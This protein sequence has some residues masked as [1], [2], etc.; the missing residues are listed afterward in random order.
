MLFQN[1]S[2]QILSDFPAVDLKKTDGSAINS[3]LIFTGGHPVIL[4]FWATWCKPCVMELSAYAENYD[5]WQK[6]TGVKIIA[7][8][9]DDSRSMSRVGSFVNGKGWNFEVYCD[10]NGD[11]KRRMNVVNVPHTFLISASR[12]IVYQH[13]A[14]ASGDEYEIFEEIK[15]MVDNK[16]ND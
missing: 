10:P 13:T 7:V 2:S 5:E 16:S 3:S 4:C 6:Q 15:K 1:L 9:V 8:S 14:Y 12:K 11:F